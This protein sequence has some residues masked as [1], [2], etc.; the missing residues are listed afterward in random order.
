M[1][2]FFINFFFRRFVMM[3]ILLTMQVVLSYEFGEM[4][5]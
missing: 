2:E 4:L 3:N 5:R 1:N